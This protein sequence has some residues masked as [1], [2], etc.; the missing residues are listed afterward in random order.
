MVDRPI[1][2]DRLDHRWNNSDRQIEHEGEERQQRRIEQP[3]SN[4]FGD[5][6]RADQA[7]AEIALDE[8]GDPVEITCDQVLIE[9]KTLPQNGKLLRVRRPPEN[10]GC[11]IPGQHFG[12]HEDDDG[13]GTERQKGTDDAARQK[14]RQWH[15]LR[16][17]RGLGSANKRIRLSFAC[18]ILE[19][20][21]AFDM[22]RKSAAAF[23]HRCDQ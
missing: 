20:H 23:T 17:S 1:A 21:P 18:D 16:A 13:H 3:S 7:L 10:A 11:N 4:D 2:V 14:N 5:R 19:H 22:R 12:D 8:A 6:L 9:A 15:L